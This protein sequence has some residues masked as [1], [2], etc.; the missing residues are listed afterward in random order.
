MLPA[1]L[2]APK[3]VWRDADARGWYAAPG[4]HEDDDRLGPRLVHVPPWPAMRCGD[5]VTIT[6]ESLARPADEHETAWRAARTVWRLARIVSMPEAGAGV[7]LTV[8]RHVFGDDLVSARMTYTVRSGRRS[9]IR[10]CSRP[11]HIKPNLD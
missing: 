11:T 2:D 4:D 7:V 1:R 3:F 10:L 8:P 9:R 5:V 6:I